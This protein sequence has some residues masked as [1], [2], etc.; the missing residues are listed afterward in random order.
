MQGEVHAFSPMPLLCYR[1]RRCFVIMKRGG[2]GGVVKLC[3]VV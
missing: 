2:G 3:E 1:Q